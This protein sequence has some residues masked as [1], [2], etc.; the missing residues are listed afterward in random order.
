MSRP[1]S[2]PRWKSWAGR[3]GLLIFSSLLALGLAEIVCR[4]WVEIGSF[5]WVADGE[6]NWNSPDPLLEYRL[7]PGWRGSIQAPEYHQQVEINSRGFRGPEP[8]PE[9][10]IWVFGD[11][12]VFGVGAELEESLPFL[13]GERLGRPVWNLGVPSWSGPQYRRDLE[14]RLAETR[15]GERPLAVAVVFFLGE[16]I[17][18][19]ND[20]I[21]ALDFLDHLEGG[22]PQREAPKKTESAKKWLSRHS[23]LYNAMLHRFAPGL[24]GLLRRHTELSPADQAKIEAGWQRLALD[25]AELAAVAER[26]RLPL[27]VAAMPE[28]GDL[29]RGDGEHL[30]RVGPRFLELAA[31]AGLPALDLSPALRAEP[32]RRVFYPRDG[33]LTARGNRLAAA[34]LAAALREELPFRELAAPN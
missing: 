17:S 34:A 26:E 21:G 15:A 25:L 3:L 6:G 7:S 19:A 33:H 14:R 30:S 20:L 28:Q 27:L 13:L 1:G 5:R 8:G 16:R 32:A 18:T 2:R 4:Q 23:A 11:S 22:R 9:P 24:R 12:F 31:A 10:A 29:A